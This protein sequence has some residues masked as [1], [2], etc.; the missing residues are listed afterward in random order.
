VLAAVDREAFHRGFRVAMLA[1]GACAAL[2]GVV[3]ALMLTPARA[4]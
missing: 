3:I 2:G 4:R 1:A